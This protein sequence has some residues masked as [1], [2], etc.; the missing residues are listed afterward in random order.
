M[1]HNAHPPHNALIRRAKQPLT[2][3]GPTAMGGIDTPCPLRDGAEAESV[4]DG[5]AESR[6]GICRRMG[7]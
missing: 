7:I 2:H 5:A 6:P 4:E 3:G 1:S